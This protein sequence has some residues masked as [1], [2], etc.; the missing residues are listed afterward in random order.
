M[1]MRYLL[2]SYKSDNYLKIERFRKHGMTKTE[3]SNE[4]NI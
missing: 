4:W 1:E 2:K 3:A